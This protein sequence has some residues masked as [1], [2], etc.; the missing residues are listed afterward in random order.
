MGVR[1]GALL[2]ALL[3]VACGPSVVGGTS[4]VT[5]P[6]ITIGVARRRLPSRSANLP[7]SAPP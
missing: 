5:P 4:E 2:V 1:I 3:L 6:V 7:S